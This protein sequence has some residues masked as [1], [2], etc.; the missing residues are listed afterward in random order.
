MNKQKCSFK[1]KVK[2]Y[3]YWY[4]KFINKVKLKKI[5]A[6]LIKRNYVTY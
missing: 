5:E 4:L 6:F 3:F 1:R 2:L